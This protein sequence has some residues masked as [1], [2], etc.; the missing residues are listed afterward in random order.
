MFTY[1]FCILQVP[2]DVYGTIY[3]K[4]LEYTTSLQVVWTVPNYSTA[5]DVCSVLSVLEIPTV[6]Y[7]IMPSEEIGQHECG[8]IPPMIGA[9]M[10]ITRLNQRDEDSLSTE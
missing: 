8:R 9:S 3:L 1:S 2:C 4:T 7:S 5:M 6:K 10:L